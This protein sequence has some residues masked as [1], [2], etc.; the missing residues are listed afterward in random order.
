MASATNIR[1]QK[2]KLLASMVW[3]VQNMKSTPKKKAL[4]ALQKL[5]RVKA[6]DDNGLCQCVSCGI[7]LHWTEMDG[8]HFIDKGHSSFWA[9][10]EEN[11]HSQCKPCNNSGSRYGTA[12]QRYTLWMV[13]YYGRD[14]VERME[15]HK[16]RP[17][18]FYKK[19]YESM[20]KA[21]NEEIK[22]HLVRIG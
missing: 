5:V 7:W 6:A 10:E 3:L 4:D 11:V 9:L 17:V 8:G 21:W 20:T 22:Q 13:D 16:R 12:K 18:K 19:D 15:T 1:Q 2:G 14:F